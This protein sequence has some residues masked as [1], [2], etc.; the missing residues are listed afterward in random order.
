MEGRIAPTAFVSRK[1][2]TRIAAI[3]IAAA[4]F[5]VALAP[6][7]G[8]AMGQAAIDDPAAPPAS[9]SPAAP[10]GALPTSGPGAP[11]STPASITPGLTFDSTPVTTAVPVAASPA[12]QPVAVA[13]PAIAPAPLPAPAPM[14][15]TPVPAALPAA[16]TTPAPAASDKGNPLTD[17]TVVPPLTSLEQKSIRKPA[18]D[19]SASSTSGASGAG[20]KLPSGITAVLQVA[21][22]LGVVIGLIFVGKGLARKYVPGAKTAGVKGAIEILARHP[23][24][25]NQSI[26]LV[27][28][29]S[30]IVALNQGKEQSQSVLVISEP[31]EVAKLLGQVEGQSP[32]SIQAGFNRL[33]ANA[34][35]DLE[36]SA[37]DP[38]REVADPVDSR[39]LDDQLEEMAA[40]RRQLMDLRTQVRTVREKLPRA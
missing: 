39:S 38:D 3:G 33:L 36:D 11:H 23:L 12:P 32:K 27:R 8:Q 10:S 21:A 19:T 17:P 4:A 31:S 5:A 7:R 13:K 25:K 30:Q 15:A 26:V 20:A 35:V 28:I 37:N 18:A 24:T 16:D 29:G 2:F 1:K 6:V 22:A 9:L 34:A 40:A 14:A